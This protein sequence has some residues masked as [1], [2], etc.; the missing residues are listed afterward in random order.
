MNENPRE[1]EVWVEESGGRTI[2]WRLYDA[3][4]TPA[5]HATVQAAAER[6]LCNPAIEKAR[7]HA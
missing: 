2:A 6:L 4:G 5:D 7:Y 1:G 3:A